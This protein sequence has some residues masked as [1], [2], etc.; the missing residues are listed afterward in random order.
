MDRKLTRV[1]LP[2]GKKVVDVDIANKNLL[3]VASPRDM[4]LLANLATQVRMALRAPIGVV[5][6]SELLIGGENLVLIV[7]DITRP[8]PDRS[9]SAYCL[10]RG[11]GRSCPSCH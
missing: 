6:F 1:S 7:D 2:Y 4:T 11:R 5:P 3:S 8:T 10:E 9:N